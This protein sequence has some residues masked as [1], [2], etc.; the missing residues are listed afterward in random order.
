VATLSGI[1]FTVSL[2]I[3]ELAFHDDP[4]RLEHVKLAVL[5]A[6][7]TASALAAVQLRRRNRFHRVATP[8][9]PPG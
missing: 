1:G 4:G 8:A 7:L 3:A 6:S 2:L 9:G 5:V